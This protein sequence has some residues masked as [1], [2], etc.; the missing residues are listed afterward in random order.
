MNNLQGEDYDYT[1]S[2]T[3]IFTIRIWNIFPID[4]SVNILR[5]SLVINRLRKMCNETLHVLKKQ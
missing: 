5:T 3:I 1:P 4:T 2:H